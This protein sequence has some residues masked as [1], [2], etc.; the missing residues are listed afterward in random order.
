MHGNLNIKLTFIAKQY[1]QKQ[2]RLH[3]I[4]R[5]LQKILERNHT[6]FTSYIILCSALVIYYAKC[7]VH[8]SFSFEFP[9]RPLY[10]DLLL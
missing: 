7:T 9:Y 2:R 1:H 6:K 4:E 8:F 5:F 10:F 3:V